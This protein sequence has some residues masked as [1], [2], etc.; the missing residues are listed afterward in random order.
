VRAAE[1]LKSDPHHFSVHPTVSCPGSRARL[2]SQMDNGIFAG[3]FHHSNFIRLASLFKLCSFARTLQLSL[4]SEDTGLPDE[5]PRTVSQLMTVNSECLVLQAEEQEVIQAIFPDFVS[6]STDGCFTFEILVESSEPCRITSS[7]DSQV[8]DSVT[9]SA[10]PPLLLHVE[11]PSDYPLW[12]PPRIISIRATHD[13]LTEVEKM[14]ASLR[15]MWVPEETVLTRWIEWINN[16]TF[17][18]EL[19]LLQVSDG[20][21][22]LHVHN[23]HIISLLKIYDLSVRQDKFSEQSFTCEVC[24]STHKGAHCILLSCGH[25]FCRACLHGF[26]NVYIAEGNIARVACPDPQCMKTPK[27]ASEDE[28]ER[29]LEPGVFERW[30]SLRTKREFEA[31]ISPVY[32]PMPN[33]QAPVPYVPDEDPNP[34]W[35]LFRACTNCGFAFCSYC[36][37]SWHGAAME[38]P[39]KKMERRM[40]DLMKNAPEPSQYAQHESFSREGLIRMY[41]DYKQQKASK[42]L[43]R[44]IAKPCPGCGVFIS[45]SYGCNHMICTKC[46]QHFCF[47]CGEKLDSYFNTIS[48]VHS[49]Y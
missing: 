7:D 4:R 39:L 13:W 15:S 24:M 49:H 47:Q 33:C 37:A 16:A 44:Q 23:H 30:K 35:Q 40:K 29:V 25:V 1:G 12:S 48:G 41:E 45:R 20:L 8:E 27:E 36:N 5:P 6:T 32:C 34:V 18:D 43:M 19:G 3:L 21:R 14:S 10:L 46:E 31:S 9:I 11:L 42:W 22:I 26:W 2:S 38:C 28:V 17:L